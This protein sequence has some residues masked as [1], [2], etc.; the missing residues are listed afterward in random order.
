[1]AYWSANIYNLYKSNDACD[2]LFYKYIFSINFI[3]YMPQI[4][5]CGGWLTF[6][7]FFKWSGEE[8]QEDNNFCQTNKEGL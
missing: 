4:Y 6:F 1:M 8:D 5:N 2:L 3:L 7:F